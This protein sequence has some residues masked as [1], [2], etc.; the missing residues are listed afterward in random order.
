VATAARVV[1]WKTEHGRL[2]EMDEY[3]REIRVLKDPFDGEPLR[4]A[5]VD[6]GFRVYSVGP[7]GVDNG[8]E[9]ES[10]AEID[11]VAVRIRLPDAAAR[12]AK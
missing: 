4:Y 11:D 3:A 7:N 12:G 2:P 1:I 9:H 5:A 6:G 10:D 8:G